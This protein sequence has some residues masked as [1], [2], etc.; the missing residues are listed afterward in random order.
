MFIPVIRRN[1]FMT[2]TSDRRWD[3]RV[4]KPLFNCC[5][6]VRRR[7]EEMQVAEMSRENRGTSRR[8][9]SP[10]LTNLLYDFLRYAR[11][12]DKSVYF[13]ESLLIT[14]L[15]T[16]RNCYNSA[17]IVLA[18]TLQT[19]YGRVLIRPPYRTILLCDAGKQ[20]ERCSS[21]TTVNT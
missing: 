3:I 1:G 14:C 19:Q 15:P 4:I 6:S 5:R 17:C 10:D 16:M 7:E 9:S 2:G 8:V 12:S 18:R 21:F 20:A 11:K 13:G